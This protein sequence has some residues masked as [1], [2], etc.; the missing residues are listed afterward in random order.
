MLAV[1]SKEFKSYF[2]SA[3]GY[4]FL[5]V[6]LLFFGIFV[7]INNL[8]NAS[9]DYAGVVDSMKIILLLLVPI[10]TMRIISEETH[11]KTDQLL[12]TAPIGLNEI[13]IG[14]YLAASALF[15]I[16]VAVTFAYPLVLSRFGTLATAQI[17]GE[18]FGFILLG[19]CFISIITECF[20]KSS[21]H[22]VISIFK[23][24]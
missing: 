17:I 4:I 1:F 7:S 15:L 13:V 22:C 14:K 23:I 24:I 10:L 6:F 11:Q 20:V 8:I 12:Y 2:Y 16:G 21:C 5:G 18:Y 3:S 9:S 19:F